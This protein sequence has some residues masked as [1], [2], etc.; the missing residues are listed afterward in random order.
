MYSKNIIYFNKAFDKIEIKNLINWFLINYGNIKTTKLLDKIKKFGLI[1]ATNAGIS[2]GLN[3]LI[4]PPSKK[5]LVEISNKNLNKINKKFKNGKI[6]L[7]TYLIKEKRT[8]D[9]MNENL[10]IESIKNLKQNDL[11]NSLY[12]MTLSGARG[13]IN[14]VKQLISMRGLISD[15]QGNLLNLPIKTNFKEGLN[16]V[17]YFISCYGARKGIIDT[18]LKTANAGYLTRRLIFASQNTIIRKTNCFT[19]YKKKIK[20]KYETKQEFK[21][22][23]EELIG[24]IN[25]KT[26]KEKD[27]NK[28]IIS[29][30]QDIC[31][32][33]KKILNH[34]INIY[35]RT[36][37]NCI[38]TT[39]ICQMCYGWNLATG[40]IVELGETIGTIAAQ[41]I[42]E[43]GTQ[44]TMR[45]F[46]LGGIFTSKIKE[47]ILSPFTGKIWY[48]LNKNGKKTYNKFNEKIF[49]TSKEKK[50]TIYENNINKSIYYLPPNS[51]IF[52]R[53]GE[54]VFKAQIIAETFDKQ[55][56]KEN[57]KFNEVKKIKSNI[58]GKKYINKKNKKFNNL[59][60]I[61][62][63]NFIT[64]N[65][66]YHKLTDKLNFKKKSYTIS[67]NMQDKNKKSKKNLQLKISIKN[68]LNNMEKKKSKTNKKFIFIN[69][70][71][72]KNKTII[73]N[74]PKKEK[75]IN[76]KWKIGK[77]ILKDEIT[78]K[79]RNLYPSQIIQEKKDTSVLKKVTPYRLNDKIL[80]KNP[81]IMKKNA[82]LYKAVTKKEKNKDIIQ[83]LVE[84]EKLFEAKKSFIIDKTKNLHEILKD[85]FVNYN[86]KYNNSTSTR[87]SIEIIQKY[88]LEEIQSIYKEQGINISN[89][90]IEIIIKQMTSKVI[91]KNA[92]NS[93]F[94]VGEICNINSID[95]LNKNYEHKIIYE[96]IL[97]GITK[98]SLYTQ[99]F[100]SQITFQ[101]SIKSL[102]KAAIENKIDWLYGLK[103]NLIL[104]NLI[105]I[106]TGFK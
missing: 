5:N 100:I 79:N 9:N 92:G 77:F 62:N 75:I 55:K 4:I 102:I 18:S 30:G 36:P 54:K 7:I 43:P 25:V 13:N 29:Y 105:P 72:N 33:F 69:E 50:I 93:P 101:E 89:K 51:Y 48:D 11:L 35:I 3:D 6:N 96:P 20:I 66:F 59:Y 31:Y 19:K 17:E 12:T 97:L 14:Q 81:Y 104:G 24:R 52:V 94:I 98:S 47:S 45:T 99:S 85:L 22:L 88:I 23:K 28:I 64:F 65:K 27:N 32:T 74:K 61:L 70:I 44:L 84:I 8:W 15:S 49:L 53:P 2:I 40:K 41:S 86:K 76:N 58:S 1:H 87:K 67:K 73:L 90:H 82:L 16:I 60:W 63:A 95:N 21:L 103:E 34:N 26:I 91:I 71:L 83:G 39:G 38:L 37:L 56:K 10:K 46:H 80:D 78:N 106:G 42:G 68:I 57:T